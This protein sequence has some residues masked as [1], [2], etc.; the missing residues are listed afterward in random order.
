[1]SIASNKCVTDRDCQIEDAR[2]KFGNCTCDTNFIESADQSKCLPCKLWRLTLLKTPRNDNAIL[3]Q[4]LMK[5]VGV[6]K[7]TSNALLNWTKQLN[8]ESLFAFASQAP[9]STI[10]ELALKTK[11]NL[12]NINKLSILVKCDLFY[13]QALDTHLIYVL[14]RT[15]A[16]KNGFVLFLFKKKIQLILIVAVIGVYWNRMALWLQSL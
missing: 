13:T 5:L 7:S 15:F 9:F 14:E 3:F 6:A 12:I 2:C 11:V 10:R 16:A 8:A 4:W 1:M